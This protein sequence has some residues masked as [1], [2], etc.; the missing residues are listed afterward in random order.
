[1]FPQREIVTELHEETKVGNGSRTSQKKEVSK[2][3]EKSTNGPKIW[4]LPREENILTKRRKTQENR[5]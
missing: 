3:K 4:F 5:I 1:M 2:K